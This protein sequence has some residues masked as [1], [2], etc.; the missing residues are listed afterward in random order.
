MIRESIRYI[1]ANVG[2]KWRNRAQ[3]SLGEEGSIHVK[4]IRRIGIRNVHGVFKEQQEKL[5]LS[6]LNDQDCQEKCQSPQACRWHHPYGRKWRGAKD[7][8]DESERGEWKS[9]LK[10]NIQKTKIMAHGPISSWQIDGERVETAT[11][12][13]IFF[14]SKITTDGD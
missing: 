8:L 14:V 4:Q 11:N 9:W 1:W 12:F 3:I 2:K 10:F 13:I 5:S 7:C 6:H